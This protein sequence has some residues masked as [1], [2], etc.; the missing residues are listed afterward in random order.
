MSLLIA[1]DFDGT[2]VG[3]GS[4]LQ[5]RPFVREALFSIK[6]AGN[7]LIL[8]SCRCNV[9]DNDARKDDET[10][11]FY[12]T[13]EVPF[14]IAEQWGRFSEM[15]AFL[16]ETSLINLFDDVWQS[17]GKPL[18]DVFVDDKACSPDW[19]KLTREYGTG[20]FKHG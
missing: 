2:I 1:V 19:I 17:P 6:Q 11:R 12:A 10:A 18:A 14:R 20:V 16:T 5:L 3:N 13:G 9:V 8:F 4:P 7:R 15:I